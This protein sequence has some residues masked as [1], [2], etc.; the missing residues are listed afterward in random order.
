MGGSTSKRESE[1]EK[2]RAALGRSLIFLFNSKC[3][4]VPMSTVRNHLSNFS[5]SL[6]DVLGSV[7]SFFQSILQHHFGVYCQQRKLLYTS[8]HPE[9][10]NPSNHPPTYSLCCNI[11]FRRRFFLQKENQNFL[12]VIG[13]FQTPHTYC[14]HLE[15][16][17][18]K[19]S[20]AI[21]SFEKIRLKMSHT[22]MMSA[23]APST[24]R[25]HIYCCMLS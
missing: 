25:P 7:E 3:L 10:S 21:F 19:L 20:V 6:L 2:R 24:L 16:A 14:D 22:S 9:T 4:F 23:F 15:T 11:L 13:N 12:V 1:S 17:R 8:T 18:K 5:K